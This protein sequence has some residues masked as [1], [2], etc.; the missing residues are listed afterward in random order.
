MYEVRLALKVKPC[1]YVYSCFLSDLWFI[2]LINLWG[3]DIF[4]ILLLFEVVSPG[5]LWI[6]WTQFIGYTP[7][8]LTLHN[9]STVSAGPKLN[10][11]PSPCYF[12]MFYCSSSGFS[13]FYPLIIVFSDSGQSSYINGLYGVLESLD[14]FTE[15]MVVLMIEWNGFQYLHGEKSDT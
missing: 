14:V 1:W 6:W 12:S 3:K 5:L 9:H 7:I 11:T 10:A 13:F 2:T 15:H 4:H 8:F